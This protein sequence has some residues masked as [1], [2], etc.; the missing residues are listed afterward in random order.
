MSL[1][2]KTMGFSQQGFQVKMEAIPRIMCRAHSIIFPIMTSETTTKQTNK[3]TSAEVHSCS[4]P[5]EFQTLIF[6][7]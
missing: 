3:Q 6:I 7:L 1:W 2:L 4:K 5:K